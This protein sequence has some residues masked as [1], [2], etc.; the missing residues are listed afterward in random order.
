MRPPAVASAVGIDTSKRASVNRAYFR[1][2][3]PNLQTP[4]RWSGSNRRCRAGNPSAAAQSATLESLNF[5][6]ALGHLA[7]VRFD[8]T[9]SAKAQK[10]ALIMSANQS[11]SHYPPRSWKCWTKA[12]YKAAGRS[13]L[14]LGY[15]ELSAGATI[16]MY[17]DDPGGSNIYVGHRRWIMYPHSTVL[18]NGATT[19]TNALWVIGPTD[20]DRPNP[21]WVGW[22]TAGWFPTPLEPIGRWSLSAGDDSTDFSDARVSVTHAGERLDVDPHP[23]AVGYGKPTLAWEVSGAD[24]PGTYRV[25]VRRIHQSGDDTVSHSYRVRLFKPSRP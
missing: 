21:A 1:R 5:V 23:V 8:K 10:A 4:I 20:F 2:L 15:P 3:K 16:T 11:L 24:R 19:T 13:N 7:P 17:M 9:L 14:A 18:G 6:R 25:T 12:G 22:P